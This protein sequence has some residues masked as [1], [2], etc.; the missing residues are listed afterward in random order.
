MPRNSP[1]KFIKASLLL[2]LLLICSLSAGAETLSL[3]FNDYLVG[4]HRTLDLREALAAQHG[5]DAR[6]LDIDAIEVIAKSAQG[7]G[8]VWTGS[9]YS[10]QDR[11][12]LPGQTQNFNN[13]ADWTFSRLLFRGGGS[14]EALQLNL[15]GQLKLRAVVLHTR[16]HGRTGEAIE[17]QLGIL[18]VHLPMHHLQLSGANNID[19]AQ[20]IHNDTSLDPRHYDLQGIDVSMKSRD[21]MGKA[22]LGSSEDRSAAQRVEGRA[23]HFGSNDPQSYRHYRFN[24]SPDGSRRATWQLQLGGDVRLNELTVYLKPR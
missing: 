22:W 21:G 16:D 10:Q 24:G 11:R 18:R 6:R 2:N 20:L 7:G 19:I 1:E 14:D 13:P 15:Y 17:H 12:T 5:R 8:Q 4:G 23:E 9:E 3:Q